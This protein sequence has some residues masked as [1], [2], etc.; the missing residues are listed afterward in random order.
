MHRSFLTGI[1][2]LIMA[3]CAGTLLAVQTAREGYAAAPAGIQI[4]NPESTGVTWSYLIDG[5]T[6]TLHAGYSQQIDSACTI[7]FDRG[8]GLGAA[9]YGL[10]DGTYTFTEVDGHWELYRTEDAPAGNAA[11]GIGTVE[12]GTTPADPVTPSEEK[13]FQD[14]YSAA[15]LNAATM[16]LVEEDW[17]GKTHAARKTDYD[18]FMAQVQAAGPQTPGTSSALFDGMTLN[19]WHLR[20]PDG[21][22]YWSAKGRE[23]V[24]TPQGVCYRKNLVTDAR[25]GDF[26]LQLEFLMADNSNSGVYLRGL[27]EIQLY[28]DDTNVEEPKQRCG[29]IYNQVAPSEQAYLGPEK[30]NTLKVKMV[31]QHVSVTMNGHCI[32]DGACPSGPTDNTETLDIKEGEPG[33]IMLQCHPGGEVKFRNISIT[34]L[35]SASGQPPPTDVVVR[36]PDSP[37]PVAPSEED[38]RMFWE[39]YRGAGL[40]KA[41]LKTV[42]DDWKSKT[43]SQRKTEYDSFMKQVEEMRQAASKPARQTDDLP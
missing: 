18:S 11:A 17:Q 26:E 41:T 4:V 30:W 23:L 3:G 9:K 38:K 28:F 27:Y 15:G 1:H 39:M 42:S 14:M 13:M 31:G 21:Q 43:S 33:P 2:W 16:K 20:D 25:F 7:D 10:T 32:V 12:E 5:Q 37:A 6:Q 36:P 22:N 29:A 8:G 35:A 40:D 34:P 19:G 24:C